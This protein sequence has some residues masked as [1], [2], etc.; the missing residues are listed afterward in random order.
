MGKTFEQ[1]HFGASVRKAHCWN[2]SLLLW[3]NAE[4][5]L[6][7][8]V[9]GKPERVAEQHGQFVQRIQDLVLED[10]GVRAVLAFLMAEPAKAIEASEY[11]KEIMEVNPFMT[12]RLN[13][14]DR[15]VWVSAKWSSKESVASLSRAVSRVSCMISG[16]RG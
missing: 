15:L 4:Y 9:K 3:D 7:L 5:V 10:Q 16:L 11:L 6:G 14:E 13:D 12:F 8:C 2:K 1:R